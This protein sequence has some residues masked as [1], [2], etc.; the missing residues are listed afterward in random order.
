[1]S[2]KISLKAKLLALSVGISTFLV[3]VGGVGFYSLERTVDD[4][5]H[6]VD[7]NFANFQL[8]AE[9]RDQQ[10]QSI[11]VMSE[12]MATD[13]KEVIEQKS[14]QFLGVVEKRDAASKKFES[15]PFVEGE[16]PIW[17]RDKEGWKAFRT[18]GQRILQLSKSGSEAD[19]A[20]RSQLYKNEF[21][22]ARQETLSALADMMEFQNQESEKWSGHAKHTAKVANYVVLGAVAVGFILAFLLGYLL[23]TSLSKTLG[24]LATQLSQGANQVATA[25]NQI[26]ST[27]QTLSSAATEQAASIEETAASLHQLGGMVE[28][29]LK[30]A[31]EGVKLSETGK[32]HAERGVVSMQSLVESMKEI[33]D[34]NKKIEQLV[35]VI[36]EI[37]EKTA[38]IDEIVFQTKLLS[39]NASVEAERAGEHGRGFAVVAPRGRK[40]GPNE[41]EGRY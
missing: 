14:T 25:A 7:I 6:V 8:L 39:F 13:S 12:L 21:F 26:S 34:S 17:A 32:G 41:R 11:I 24:S 27:S 10:R 22:K 3:I 15:I 19:L 31:E 16:A 9:I 35:K 20:A 5:N 38:V 36:E 18:H 37:G 29:N 30:N 4:Y 40:L 2:M 23:A 28:R 33:L 1:M